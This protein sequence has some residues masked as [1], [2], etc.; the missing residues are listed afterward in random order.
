LVAG[1]IDEGWN[2]LEQNL[3]PAVKDL[4]FGKL[5]CPLA[6]LLNHGQVQGGVCKQEVD[7]RKCIRRVL[8][9]NVVEGRLSKFE[10]CILASE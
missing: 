2:V 6:A 9:L 3:D 7:G 8:N 10:E 4:L 5:R 1:G